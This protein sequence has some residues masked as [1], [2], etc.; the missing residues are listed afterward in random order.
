MCRIILVRSVSDPGCLSRIP[1]PDFSH[2]RVSDPGSRIQNPKTRKKGR[3]FV[4]F[5]FFVAIS[6]TK[7]AEN[8][9]DLFYKE[10]K[11][12]PKNSY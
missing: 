7:D 6:F 9:F 12:Y 2:P 5:S 8:F 4:F 3:G 11:W 10:L 1:N